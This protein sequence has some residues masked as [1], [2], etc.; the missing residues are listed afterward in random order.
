MN[1]NTKQ[2]N[3]RSSKSV[4][5]WLFAGAQN[6]NRRKKNKGKKR[7]KERDEVSPGRRAL[8]KLPQAIFE[9]VFRLFF[10]LF[11]P[12]EIYFYSRFQRRESDV[13]VS[14]RPCVRQCCHRSRS[15]NGRNFIGGDK[16]ETWWRKIEEGEEEK[17]EGRGWQ[18]GGGAHHRNVC[19]KQCRKQQKVSIFCF[20]KSSIS[21]FFC[22]GKATLQATR[23]RIG[24]RAL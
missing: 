8:S 4:P 24:R 2:S 7:K 16:S 6:V 15:G 9:Y 21:F 18:W 19:G 11:F 10:S 12:S 14:E 23:L 17:E 13:S 1:N 20:F 5:L 3:Q 22:C